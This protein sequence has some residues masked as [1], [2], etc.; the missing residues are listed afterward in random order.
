[1]CLTDLATDP[2]SGQ[3]NELTHAHTHQTLF[4]SVIYYHHGYYL[5]EYDI[6]PKIKTL[7]E[8]YHKDNKIDV[9]YIFTTYRPTDFPSNINV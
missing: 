5:L 8:R 9:S 4:A 3:Q 1:M 2:Q 7:F 6:A